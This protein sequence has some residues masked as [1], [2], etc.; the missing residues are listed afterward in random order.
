MQLFESC[1]LLVG[2]GEGAELGVLIMSGEKGEADRGA[3]TADLVVVAGIDG[4]WSRRVEVRALR[5]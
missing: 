1:C 2:A 4:G 3:G 5:A